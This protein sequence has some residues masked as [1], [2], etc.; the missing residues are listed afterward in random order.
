MQ[1]A[2][3][4]IAIPMPQA[5]LRSLAETYTLSIIY[6]NRK[7]PVIKTA[8]P[9]GSFLNVQQPYHYSD[10]YLTNFRDDSGTVQAVDLAYAFYAAAPGWIK[11]LIWINHLIFKAVKN[12]FK[13]KAVLKST[14]KVMEKIYSLDILYKT[15]DEIVFGKTGRHV[16]IRYSTLLHKPRKDGVQ[17]NV[18]FS[19]AVTFHTRFGRLYF[20]II[21]PLVLW[22]TPLLLKKAINRLEA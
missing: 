14:G 1:A 12:I 19:T 16:D 20:C 6:S 11:V 13:P 21:K 22:L 17:K 4:T 2:N 18:V 15:D 10:S 9:E 7:A 5:T 3:A 8:L